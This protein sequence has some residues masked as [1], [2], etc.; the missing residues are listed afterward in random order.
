MRD[1]EFGLKYDI[2]D[3]SGHTGLSLHEWAI[4][5]H[6]TFG[7]QYGMSALANEGMPRTDKVVNFRGVAYA[8][9][10][11]GFVWFVPDLH[12]TSD[13]DW[14][15]ASNLVAFDRWHYGAHVPSDMVRLGWRI[16]AGL[17]VLFGEF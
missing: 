15:A 16:A 6:P 17:T 2:N 10:V 14:D 9:G 12:D 4:V 7:V 5:T 3:Q 11:D 8:V 13:L 1:T